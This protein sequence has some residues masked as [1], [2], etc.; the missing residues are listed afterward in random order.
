MKTIMLDMDDTIA[1]FCGHSVFNGIYPPDVSHMYE[2]GFF[3][4]LTP[5]PGALVAVRALIR[6]GYDVQILSQPLAESPHSYSEKVQWIGIW[7]PELI[8]KINFTQDKGL[9]K[10]DYLIDDNKEKWKEKFEKNGGQFVH[11]DYVAASPEAKWQEIV[12]FFTQEPK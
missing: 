7:F 1:D 8:T 11:F 10:A 3:F 6:M 5:V 2:Q 4:S 9:I 12:K